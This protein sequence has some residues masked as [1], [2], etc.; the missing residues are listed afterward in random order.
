[1]FLMNF[2]NPYMLDNIY[3]VKNTDRKALFIILSELID[4]NS[5]YRFESDNLGSETKC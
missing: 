5:W 2:K 3:N 1:M 4:F